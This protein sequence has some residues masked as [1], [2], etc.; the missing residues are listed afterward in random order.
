MIYP[1]LCPDCKHEFSVIKALADIDRKE[2]CG[3]C[4]AVSS[5]TIGKPYIGNTAEYIAN[6]NPAFGKVVKSKTHEREILAEFKAKGKEMEEIG[7]EPLEKIHV[8][9]DNKREQIRKDKWA[10]ADREKV[11]E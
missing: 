10:D 2:L 9:H 11:Y 8:Y 6:F 5:R 4:S 1:Y 7:T 3:K